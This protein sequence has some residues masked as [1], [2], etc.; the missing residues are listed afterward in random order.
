[1][2]K[3]DM[4]TYLVPVVNQPHQ[5]IALRVWHTFPILLL[6]EHVVELIDAG[7]W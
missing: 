1:M 3:G 6:T 2:E 5:I 7:I 4:V